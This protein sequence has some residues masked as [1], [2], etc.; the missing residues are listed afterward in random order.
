MSSSNMA[1]PPEKS[2]DLSFLGR[3]ETLISIMIAPLVFNSK[4]TSSTPSRR[5]PSSDWE[6]IISLISIS[7]LFGRS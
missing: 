1:K 5:L 3:P 4:R 2:S 6:I 7:E